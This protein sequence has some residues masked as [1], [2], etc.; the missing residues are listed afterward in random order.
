MMKTP[1]LARVVLA[2]SVL[3]VGV[4]IAMLG[5]HPDQGPVYSV[6][7]VQAELAHRPA[8]WVGRTARVRGIGIFFCQHCPQRQTYLANA[9]ANGVLPLAWGRQ[10]R[11]LAFLRRMPQVGRLV[12]APQRVRWGVVAI[13]RVQLRELA[14]DSCPFAPWPCYEAL[15]LDAAP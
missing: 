5:I 9:D 7:Q 10:D 3:A 1:L 4:G 12:P 8:A 15:L 2:C 11:V 13:Y 14:A 6:A